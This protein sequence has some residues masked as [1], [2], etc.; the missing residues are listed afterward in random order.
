[1]SNPS[2]PAKK[3]CDHRCQNGGSCKAKVPDRLIVAACS[4]SICLLKKNA[5]HQLMPHNSEPVFASPQAFTDYMRSKSCGQ[6]SDQ[7][8]LVGSGNDLA[9]LSAI[10][11]PELSK[12]VVAE[13]AY[14]LRNEW[15]HEPSLMQLKSALSP[16]MQ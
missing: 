11:T 4:G 9:W 16:L 3:A 1:M 6:H 2:V 5:Q 7:L 14:P 15:F 12:R 8:V 10:L 13:M